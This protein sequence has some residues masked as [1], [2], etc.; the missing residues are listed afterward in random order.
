MSG[1]VSERG[2]E[3]ARLDRIARQR[4]RVPPAHA[5]PD[6]LARAPLRLLHQ[7]VQRALRFIGARAHHHRAR[8]IG[9]IAIDDGAKV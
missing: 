1:G 3:A 4:I 2:A 6:P 5:G 9:A 8:H 7:A